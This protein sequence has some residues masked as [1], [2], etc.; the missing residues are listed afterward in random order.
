MIRGF[1]GFGFPKAHAAAFG[2]LAYQSTWLRVH[3]P[4]E[5]LCA[6]LNE[7]PMGFYSAD[8]LI[9]EAKRSA[10]PTGLEVLRP[11]VNASELDCTVTAEGAVQMGLRYVK[12]PDRR[13]LEELVG[14]RR[15][16]GAFETIQDLASRSGMSRQSLSLLAFA[17]AIPGELAADRRE[18]LWRLGVA[19][20]ARAAAPGRAGPHRQLALPLDL[21]AAPG[22]PGLGSWE[23]MVADYAATGVSV[24]RHPLELLRE[25]LTAAGALSMADLDGVRHGDR[26]RVGGLVIAR[27]RP[28]TAGGIMFLLLEDEHG[29]LNVIVSRELYERRRPLLRAEPL[30][31]VGGRL[32]RHPG[33]GGGVNLIARQ[34]ESLEPP[35]RRP[36]EVAALTPPRQ[37]EELAG[38]GDEGELA[39]LRPHAP[40]AVHF[41]QGRRR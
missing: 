17:G 12:G 29:T 15:R 24:E 13:E 34:I 20:S 7:Q 28:Q 22:L 33:G 37:P 1:S 25:E 5:F 10:G 38:E 23:A 18:A 36:A 39:D 16:G 40:P 4:P 19:R 11:D 2:L 35:G 6:L 8:A 9:H 3:Y 30:L 21:P 14:A 32:E 27:Q 41:A 31:V 26:I